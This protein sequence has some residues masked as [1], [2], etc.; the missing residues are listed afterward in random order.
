[1]GALSLR[2]QQLNVQ[3]ETKTKDNVFV[4]TRIAVQYEVH[5]ED[6]CQAYY[7]LTDPRGQITSYV[8]DVVRSYIPRID[9]DDVFTTKE[10]IAQVCARE[11]CAR[12][13]VGV[14]YGRCA[15]RELLCD[16]GRDTH[17][18]KESAPASMASLT[19][20]VLRSCSRA[21]PRA[22]LRTCARVRLQLYVQAV[23]D[24]LGKAMANYGYEILQTLVTDI[25]PAANVKAAMNDINAAHRQR[26]ATLERAEA[27]KL[28]IVKAAEADA[29]AKFL[30]GQGIARQRQ[31]IVSGLRDSV[32]DFQV[33]TGR[34]LALGCGAVYLCQRASVPVCMIS[35]ATR[36]ADACRQCGP[37]TSPP[38]P[39]RSWHPRPLLRRTSATSTRV[40]CS[41][42]CLPRSTL[43][44]STPSV[45]PLAPAPS[46]C[47][48]AP[49]P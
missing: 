29:E 24:E 48:T 17:A 23:K 43:T 15:P 4:V 7:K 35:P 11:L 12:V 47:R 30:A 16:D 22:R 45:A 32:N 25:E 5:R 26:V 38:P 40:R 27:E 33:R 20:A 6:A 31:A 46:S 28:Q 8:F 37:P 39:R 44:R 9:L 14:C 13:R 19:R 10:E 36:W 1:M 42:W 21:C 34:T 3:C 18:C 2:V 49:P 41:I